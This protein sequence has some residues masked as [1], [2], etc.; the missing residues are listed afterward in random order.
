MSGND[1]RAVQEVLI[2]KAFYTGLI[3]GYYGPI[4]EKAVT[5]YQFSVGLKADG[6]VGF[7]T[8]TKLFGLAV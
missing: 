7:K 8:W 4:T 3:D 5:A 1:V 6:I 2:V